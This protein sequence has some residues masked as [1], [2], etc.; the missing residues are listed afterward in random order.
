VVDL[1][2]R[3]KLGEVYEVFAEDVSVWDIGISA[4]KIEGE[5]VRG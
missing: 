5:E 3:C 4:S 2:D 1:V